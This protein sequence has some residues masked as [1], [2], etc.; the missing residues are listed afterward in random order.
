[1]NRI[2]NDDRPLRVT[3][4]AER[5]G[6]NLTGQAMSGDEILRPP[7]RRSA[8]AQADLV[9]NEAWLSRRQERI[10]DPDIA[11]IDAHHHLW[12]R[13]RQPRY[14]LDDLLAD[15]GSGH[16][17]LSTVFVECGTM[18]RVDGPEALRSVGQTEFA[19]GMAAMS[20][21]GDYGTVRLCAGIVGSIDLR[22]GE[23]AKPVLE[24]HIAA[25]GARFRG[26]RQISAW[27]ADSNVQVHGIIPPPDLLSDRTFRLGFAHLAPLGL[28]FDAWLYHPQLAELAELAKR[29]P[30]T[31][32]VVNHAGGPIGIG[33]YAAKRNEAFVEW[34]RGMRRLAE[35]PN[36]YAKLGGLGMKLGGFGFQD[37]DS[38]PSSG[39]L[40][41]AWRPYV[42]TCI[43]LFGPDRCMF[44][45]NFP[46]EKGA[47]SYVVLWNS[48]KRLTTGYSDTDKAKLFAG[49]AAR[50]YRLD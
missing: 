2:V 24:A 9:F 42:E 14:L 33:P 39:D 47:C 20:A 15:V 27:N 44:E 21:S 25:G 11:I 22:L 16:K 50:F 34:E 6:P 28:S 45:S 37:G 4:K 23:Q 19:N 26:I 3:Q 13:S 49:T 48:F 46:V 38:P 10:L 41:T 31:Q 36:I 8:A 30:Q 29:F 32:I 7:L 17:I 5:T 43:E 1:M 35:L 12:D 40:A 18:Y